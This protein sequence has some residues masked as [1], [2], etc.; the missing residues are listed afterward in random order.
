[1]RARRAR[2]VTASR[3]PRPP[4]EALREQRELEGSCGAIVEKSLAQ[5]AAEMERELGTQV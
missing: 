2:L 3:A 1:M 5:A 4:Q